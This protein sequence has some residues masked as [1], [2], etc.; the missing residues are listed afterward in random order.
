[1]PG[2]TGFLVPSGDLEK[3]RGCLLELATD[4]QLRERHG[5]RGR[6]IV[7]ELFSTERMVDDCGSIDDRFV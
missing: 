1:V 5:R 3:L 7:E 6:Q 2:E 4:P